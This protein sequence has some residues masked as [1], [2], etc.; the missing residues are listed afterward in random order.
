MMGEQKIYSK[1]EKINELI[2]NKG[3]VKVKAIFMWVKE[4][5]AGKM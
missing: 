1:A 5:N 4:A 2:V 3:F